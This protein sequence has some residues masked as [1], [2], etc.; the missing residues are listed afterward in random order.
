MSI[1]E[2]PSIKT[3]Y[4]QRLESKWIPRGYVLGD[5]IGNS[6]AHDRSKPAVACRSNFDSAT[7]HSM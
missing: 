6:P 4:V 7:S 5:E 1:G 2:F 3:W